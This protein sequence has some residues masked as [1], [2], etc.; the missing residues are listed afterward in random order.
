MITLVVSDQKSK[1]LAYIEAVV[2]NQIQS[3]IVVYDDTYGTVA[4][5]EQYLYPSLFNTAPPIVHLK[6]LL[7]G[8]TDELTSVFTKK[9]LASP[10]LFLFEEMALSKSVITGLKKSGAVVH[11]DEPAKISKKESDI[12]A[13]TK[14]FTASDKKARWMAYQSALKEHSI[15]AIIGILYWKIKDLVSK[16]KG[17]EKSKYQKLYH[18][19][20]DAHTRAWQRGAPLA[21]LIEKVILTQ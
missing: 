7:D 14:V 19:L 11:S 1:R 3:E 4:E 21:L 6:Y 15:E 5:L 2:A 8:K 12:F 10:T 9:L 20:L 17:V 16:S 13:V 18:D